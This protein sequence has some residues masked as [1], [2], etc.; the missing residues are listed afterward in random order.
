V[1]ARMDNRPNQ[2]S[3]EPEPFDTDGDI[4]GFSQH[5]APYPTAAWPPKPDSGLEPALRVIAEQAQK[6]T[7]ASGSAIA[8]K[9]GDLMVCRARAGVSAPAL[10]AQL[11]VDSG[12]SGECMRT[13]QLLLCSDA[14]NDPRVDIEVCRY[15]GIRSVVVV[16]IHVESDLLGIF[17]VFAPEPNVFGPAEITALQSLRDLSVSVLRPLPAVPAIEVEPAEE[18]EGNESAPSALSDEESLESLGVDFELQNLFVNPDPEDDLICEREDLLLCE[19]D[20]AASARALRSQTASSIQPRLMEESFVQFQPQPGAG[21]GYP[22]SRKLIL[23]GVAFVLAASLFL[24][25]CSGKH[26][27]PPVD[28]MSAPSAQVPQ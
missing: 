7:R 11:S 5:P 24:G 22:V 10:G 18:E 19:L 27:Q 6:V 23:A 8:L 28:Q 4:T 15:L 9:A 1:I 26:A 17:E 2:D 16:P 21:A 20:N 25:W 3:H 12:L 13:G 14:E